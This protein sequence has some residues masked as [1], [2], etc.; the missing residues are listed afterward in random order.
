MEKPA[1]RH[2]RLE[3]RKSPKLRR[4]RGLWSMSAFGRSVTGLQRPTLGRFAAVAG[5]S[6]TNGIPD[7][8]A[9]IA[10]QFYTV[11]NRH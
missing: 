8:I 7:P 5:R 3:R 6:R 4:S 1:V 9:D 11:G 10:L 2:T